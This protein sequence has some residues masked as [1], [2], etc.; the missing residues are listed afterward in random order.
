[1]VCITARIR[2]SPYC[3]KPRIEVAV[4]VY[5]GANRPIVG[6]GFSPHAILQSLK[7]DSCL[8][9]S[10]QSDVVLLEAAS[11]IADAFYVFLFKIY[12]KIFIVFLIHNSH[13]SVSHGTFLIWDHKLKEHVFLLELISCIGRK[14]KRNGF[15]SGKI[16]KGRRAG[17]KIDKKQSTE[18]NVLYI[19]CCELY[20]NSLHSEKLVTYFML[21]AKIGL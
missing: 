15:N 7:V 16:N 8:C 9:F 13:T 4:S 17:F 5:S 20:C 19:N 1:M 12:F 10:W 14:T 3:A 2:W 18:D 21:S 6:S 11:V